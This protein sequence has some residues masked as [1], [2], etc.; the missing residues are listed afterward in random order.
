[1]IDLVDVRVRPGSAGRRGRDEQIDR[2]ADA[3]PGVL[4]DVDTGGSAETRGDD[5]REQVE[6]AVVVGARPRELPRLRSV[7]R[8]LR[9]HA[10]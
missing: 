3:R 1:M 6:R 7:I 5:E 8:D 9:R 10:L 2:R 4:P